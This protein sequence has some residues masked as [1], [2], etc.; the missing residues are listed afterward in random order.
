MSLPDLLVA[1]GTV[2]AAACVQGAVGFGLS[3]LAVPILLLIDPSLVPVPLIVASLTINVGSSYRNRGGIDRGVRWALLGSVPGTVLGAWA[4]AILPQR[5]LAITLGV[6]TLAAVVVSA[7][8]LEVA[9]TTGSLLAAGVISGF[10]GTTSSIGGPPLAL[11]YQRAHGSIVRGTLAMYFLV[12]SVLSLVALALFGK[13]GE[14]E[15]ASSAL[16]AP[17]ILLGF[18]CSKPAARLLDRG[19]TRG[20]VLVVSTVSALVLIGNQLLRG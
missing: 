19:R 15:L 10:T 6:L 4:I 7:S 17:F 14:R 18:A 3:L 13:L 11:M 8:G 1:G 5:P 12:G 2:A 16:L 9:P 20:A